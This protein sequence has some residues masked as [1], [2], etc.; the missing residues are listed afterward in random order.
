MTDTYD[1]TTE[2]S[3]SSQGSVASVV[4]NDKPK[5]P[6]K[7]VRRT[8]D[9]VDP[10]TSPRSSS[11]SSSIKDVEPDGKTN[12]AIY[13]KLMGRPS[14]KTPVETEPE[15]SVEHQRKQS[16]ERQP[17]QSDER[18][19]KK[20]VEPKQ[21][22]ELED[23]PK[24]SDERQPKQSVERQPKQSVERQPK[25]S[26]EHQP[27]QLDERQPKQSVE[28]QPKQSDERKPKQSVERQPKQSDERKPKQSDER[29]PKQSDERKPKQS[30]ERQPKQ[31]DERKPKQSDERKP[32]QSDERQ[33]KQSVE[34]QPKQSDER[35]PKQSDERKPKQLVEP[36]PKQSVEHQPKQSVER[37]PKQSDERQPKQSDERKP[38]QSVERQPKQSD[39]RKPKQSVERQPKQSVERQ[40][41]QSDERQPKQSDERKPKQS[42][43]RKP[44]QSD[45]RQP[46]QSVEHQP[47]QL[48]KRQPKQER[49]VQSDSVTD[50]QS[51]HSDAVSVTDIQ[52]DH[53][54]TAGVTDSESDTSTISLEATQDMLIDAGHAKFNRP[55]NYLSKS[56]SS[57][58]P[59]VW[60]TDRETDDSAQNRR[61]KARQKQ[62]T[63]SKSKASTVTPPADKGKK[64][65]VPTGNDSVRNSPKPDSADERPASQLSKLS[66]W[67]GG[68][69]KDGGSPEKSAP[70]IKR[71]VSLME[72]RNDSDR[73]GLLQRSSSTTGKYA[74]DS[75]RQRRSD[76][77]PDSASSYDSKPSH[78]GRRYDDDYS[79][80]YTY[81]NRRRKDSRYHDDYSESDYTSYTGYSSGSY[82][83]D[84]SYTSGDSWRRPRA[85]FTVHSDSGSDTRSYDSAR[86]GNAKNPRGGDSK[87]ADSDSIYDSERSNIYASLGK[88]REDSMRSS[89]KEVSNVRFDSPAA[90]Y[91]GSRRGSRDATGSDD[92]LSESDWEP[93]KRHDSYTSYSDT[94]S[95]SYVDRKHDPPRD[96]DEDYP[97][98]DGDKEYPR[99][100]GDKEYPREDGDRRREDVSSDAACRSED[101]TKSES[102]YYSELDTSY[103]SSPNGSGSRQLGK[104]PDVPSKSSSLGG[105]GRLDSDEMSTGVDSVFSDP[106]KSPKESLRGAGSVGDRRANSS[107]RAPVLSD[108][109]SN[110]G[111]GK[112][113][114]KRRAGPSAANQ[115]GSATETDASY[116]LPDSETEKGK[117][118]RKS[119]VA[120][121]S[122]TSEAESINELIY[123]SPPRKGK[124]LSSPN[125]SVLQGRGKGQSSPNGS[126]LQRKGEGQSSPNGSVLQG[127]GKGQSSPNGS[128]LQG[129]G[130]GQSSPN[131][132]VLQGKGKGQSSPNGSVLQGKG[133]GQSSPNG[134]VLQGKGKGQSSPNGSVLQRKGEGQSSP[135]GSVLQGK[136]KGQSSP[137]GSVLQG[138]GKGQ[139]SPNGSVLQGKG[140]GQSSPNG[141]VLQGKNNKHRSVGS[142]R[143]QA[144]ST[145]DS[146]DDAKQRRTTRGKAT[147]PSDS[148]SDSETVA[149]RKSKV[150]PKRGSGLGADQIGDATKNDSKVSARGDAKPKRSDSARD[151]SDKQ[152]GVKPVTRRASDTQNNGKPFRRD[153]D[154]YTLV[155]KVRK[156]PLVV[157]DTQSDTSESS[158]VIKSGCDSETSVSDLDTT[159]SSST[160]ESESETAADVFARDS[161]PRRSKLANGFAG[162]TKKQGVVG[163]LPKQTSSEGEPRGN[164]AKA[165]KD[166]KV[167]KTPQHGGNNSKTTSGSTQTEPVLI[168]AVRRKDDKTKDKIVIKYDPAVQNS[169]FPPDPG[170]KRPKYFDKL[171]ADEMQEIDDLYAAILSMP[172][173][174]PGNY[175]RDD[176]SDDGGSGGGGS[177]FNPVPYR[178]STEF[179]QQHGVYSGELLPR[180]KMVTPPDQPLTITPVSPW[181]RGGSHVDRSAVS[182][183]MINK[184]MPDIV[185]MRTAGVFDLTGSVAPQGLG[186]HKGNASVGPLDHSAIG[187]H[188]MA[189]RPQG[190]PDLSAI[191]PPHQMSG[192]P[193]GPLDRSAI[194]PHQ[195]AGRP[196]FNDAAPS[197]FMN[198]RGSSMPD[199]LVRSA[200]IYTQPI[201]HDSSAEVLS[202]PFVHGSSI[203][204]RT[205]PVNHDSGTG[206]RTQPVNNG[207][208]AGMGGRPVKRN[209]VTGIHT[210]PGM[211]DGGTGIRTQPF[212]HDRTAAMRSQPVNSGSGAGLGGQPVKRNSVT[213]MQPQPVRHDGSTGMHT[214]PVNSGIG[215]GGQ[216]VKRNSVTGMQ[217][218]PVRHDGSAG[219]HTQPI[220]H[221][222][223]AGMRIQPVNSGI[224]AGMGGQPVKR[225][226]VTGMQPQP[227]RHDG[228]AGMH[229]QP[230]R[231]DSGAGMRTQ[232]VNS[233]IGAGM[234]EQPVKRNSITGMQPQPV[235]HDGSA[236]MHTQ[237]IRHD[238]SAG[239]HTQPIRHDGSAGTHTQPIRHDG[240]AGMHT[241]P[242]RHD[243]SAGTLRQPINQANSC[244]TSPTPLTQQGAP[245]NLIPPAKFDIR[246]MPGEGGVSVG[247]GGD[248]NLKTL[249]AVGV[250][251][252]SSLQIMVKPDRI[253]PDTTAVLQECLYMNPCI[254][255]SPSANESSVF[256]AGSFV[257]RRS[258]FLNSISSELLGLDLSFED[259]AESYTR[260]DV[261]SPVSPIQAGCS[262]FWNPYG[263]TGVESLNAPG[264]GNHNDPLPG[265]SSAPVFDEPVTHP[266]FGGRQRATNPPFADSSRQQATHSPVSDTRGKM[267]TSRLDGTASVNEPAVGKQAPVVA[268]T[269]LSLL[270]GSNGRERNVSR[271]PQVRY[272]LPPVDYVSE[273]DTDVSTSETG[274]REIISP[275]APIID[276]APAAPP[277]SHSVVRSIVAN[278]DSSK[279]V[280]HDSD[281]ASW[282]T[283]DTVC[284][285]DHVSAMPPGGAVC[286][287]APLVGW[288]A[289][290]R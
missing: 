131:G 33:P 140:K 222:S 56:P 23:Q 199:G 108:S 229:T 202:Q 109:D 134:S 279:P 73:P 290:L 173:V 280:F 198:S 236:G 127:R 180:F 111:G 256:E 288:T 125:G 45:E 78:V 57:D 10:I 155:N 226:S 273:S 116:D 149:T 19:P 270:D 5:V 234:D 138:R 263:A 232:P 214:Q 192:R 194:G 110:Y 265:K 243:G 71:S 157:E 286:C 112:S 24:Q 195:M 171:F 47:N 183:D 168:A 30:V 151:V 107:M 152:N 193:Q 209:S 160:S 163:K 118:V 221:D 37:K 258:S 289:S 259:D 9:L 80:D 218:Q 210:Q 90:R 200:G 164:P 181:G 20:L 277:G 21:S 60:E 175:P 66:D 95:R 257:S 201:K 119:Q 190:T 76:D 83:S 16:A 264:S 31:S 27:N 245:S 223:G 124:V 17:K 272:A 100:D 220:R 58:I 121:L 248:S 136:G 82:D 85:R 217:P 251:A 170:W 69:A 268:S 219:M 228:S 197:R 114:D 49:Y 132:S 79:S 70:G 13:M 59:V 177:N 67:F 205:P 252:A 275:P 156:K 262:A 145:D 106:N 48:V 240:S 184:M 158:M 84:Y 187:P 196:Q 74:A 77:T 115:N 120:M 63:H 147:L 89:N 247:L 285:R 68:G 179:P 129:K 282:I 102:S 142:L 287:V 204:M 1:G 14:S 231:H 101:P 4:T 86:R 81:L 65:G 260:D 98:R 133:K 146:D 18:Q 216:P 150:N 278:L 62:P 141:S 144:L 276:M 246:L 104:K 97:R 206:I 50:T 117:D 284:C 174:E 64:S 283:D 12:E 208:S 122:E 161:I 3:E 269:R 52:S 244:G 123:E 87:V 55:F 250:P 6:K 43:E 40:P 191:G 211:H 159:K 227:V 128:V 143:E 93:R 25:Q 172:E 28:R 148:D 241:Q 213:G 266:Q 267:R 233:G 94:D 46:K 261:T 139:S 54:D 61:S 42:D 185:A 188:Q 99:R 103:R 39:E 235:R 51:E 224:G 135:N 239:M 130:K 186:L 215:M 255:R 26:V 44:K 32:K 113:G 22:V 8:L 137:N 207:I 182:G 38:K 92:M 274:W 167:K 2:S 162:D 7:V 11:R 36:Q 166:S 238:G 105:K 176:A 249:A 169:L 271:P 212:I 178:L 154:E 165:N 254:V 96:G 153:E 34:P 230:I 53:I 75:S 41:K 281:P 126:V 242:I 29:Q 15:Q 88:V 253:K 237:P 35:K 189:G 225:D 72:R 203:W 91:K